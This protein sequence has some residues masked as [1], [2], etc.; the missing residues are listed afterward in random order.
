[1]SEQ[2]FKRKAGWGQLEGQLVKRQKQ[3]VIMIDDGEEEEDAVNGIHQQTTRTDH[4][5]GHTHQ[6]QDLE[7]ITQAQRN[8][9]GDMADW[10]L[11]TRKLE[12][13]YETLEQGLR[14]EKKTSTALSTQ[15]R[16]I[17]R[18]L[19]QQ[20][21]ITN[22]LRQR[23]QN[24]ERNS[25]A[26]KFGNALSARD[27]AIKISESH[28]E[29]DDTAI[30][31]AIT[32]VRSPSMGNGKKNM[33]V[34]ETVK[35]TPAALR[36]SP[37]DF[38]PCPIMTNRGLGKLLLNMNV[39]DKTDRYWKLY[40]YHLRALCDLDSKANSRDIS[41]FCDTQNFSLFDVDYVVRGGKSAAYIG[42][43]PDCAA[44]TKKSTYDGM[45]AEGLHGLRILEILYEE[46][47]T[48]DE[49]LQSRDSALKAW[50]KTTTPRFVY[51]LGQLF[52][53]RR[54]SHI[55]DHRFELW[56][57]RYNVVIDIMSPRKPVWLVLRPEFE[58]LP[59]DSKYRSGMHQRSESPFPS[60]AG[61]KLGGSA[62]AQ[63]AKG[64]EELKFSSDSFMRGT[65]SSFFIASE[66]VHETL[67]GETVRLKFK[68]PNL[69]RMAQEM[70]KGR[71]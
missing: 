35:N 36:L 5:K 3:E 46:V 70:A 59:S 26:A 29:S 22:M 33:S 45:N 58:P 61:W 12:F 23:V 38:M 13:Q 66:L 30:M 37:Q 25:T 53:H 28:G 49:Q 31:R 21:E 63:L 1:M 9:T 50:Q 14:L 4:K 32:G 7:L 68:T 41:L 48:K 8:L 47:F 52:V 34:P 16:N 39:S 24:L 20:D 42:D 64:L 54:G 19:T 15:L 69:H 51:D 40:S 57:T 18:T 43:H 6:F 62:A 67:S 27:S 56:D 65:G 11:R 44:N 71:Q 55:K 60:R 2:Y 10:S 17:E